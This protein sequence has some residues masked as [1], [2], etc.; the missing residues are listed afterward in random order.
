MFDKIIAFFMSIISFFLSLFGINI[1]PN[2]VSFENVSY[3]TEDRQVLDLYIPEEHDGTIGLVLMIHGGAW[4]AGDKESYTTNVKAVAEDYGCAGATINYRY[5]SETVTMQD[6]L[7]DITAATA[8]IKAI[9]EEN[10]VVIDKMILSG[11]SAGG[12]LSLL[13]AYSQADVAAI[14]PVAVVNFCGPTDFT[15]KNFLSSNLGTDN[16]C[17]LF[18]WSTGTQITAENM[19]NNPDLL[20]VSPITYAATAVPT[21]TA[22]GKNDITVPFSNA[23]TLDDALKNAGVRHDFIPYPNSDH[24]LSGDKD[25]E[26]KVY[27]LYIQYVNE[28]L[29]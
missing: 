29:K 1:D 6:I 10:G 15:D 12:H 17:M 28:Y 11:M 4:V 20:A 24:G 21:V 23:E 2:Y 13:Y 14:K 7:D 8:K 26:T 3:G 9:G 27:E 5:L 18:S 22:H 16:I 19:E 25:C